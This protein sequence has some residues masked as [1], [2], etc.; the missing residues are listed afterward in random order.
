MPALRT[1]GTRWLFDT[2]VGTDRDLGFRDPHLE[3]GTAIE[4]PLGKHF[5]I[6]GKISYSPDHKINNGGNSLSI[7]AVA[8]GWLCNR[9]GILGKIHD[10]RLWTPQ[11]DKQ[12]TSPSVGAV[13]RMRE[14][15]LANRL[16]LSY[17]LPTGCTHCR[18]QGSRLQGVDGYWEFR[19]FSHL[20]VG[21][22]MGIFT[23]LEQGNPLSNAPRTRKYAVTDAFVFRFVRHSEDS[24]EPY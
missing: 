22:R 8:I 14:F 4:Q 11:F 3:F 5:E 19:L 2:E 9:A 7:D 17:V 16:Y 15:G 1:A 20:R 18:I 21:T 10:T 24:T 6:Q 12:A 23:F 13:F